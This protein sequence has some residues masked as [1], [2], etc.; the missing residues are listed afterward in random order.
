MTEH[1]ARLDAAVEQHG[2]AGLVSELRICV[3]R[4]WRERTIFVLTAM[5][6]CTDVND[7]VGLA[8]ADASSVIADALAAYPHDRL[9]ACAGL[10][11][12]S[13]CWGGGTPPFDSDWVPTEAIVNAILDAAQHH[14]CDLLVQQAALRLIKVHVNS[15]HQLVQAPR[16]VETVACAMRAFPR[17]DTIQTWGAEAV[18]AI[19]GIEPTDWVE[20]HGE[21]S[22]T[23]LR[24]TSIQLAMTAPRPSTVLVNGVAWQDKLL[25]LFPRMRS[26]AK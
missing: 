16:T 7:Q 10:C 18:C 4:A 12:L 5:G 15:R 3:Q 24:V 19:N 17:D 8:R 1:L 23:A 14:K 9:I 11:A 21:A 6:R 13:R 25:Q 22:Y 26:Q 20:A 2:P